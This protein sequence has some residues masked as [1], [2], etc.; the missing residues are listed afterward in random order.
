MAADHRLAV[1]VADRYPSLSI[2]ATVGGQ[3]ERFSDVLDQW[4]TNLA[5]NLL[6]P[7]FAGGRLTA[8]ADRNRAV[9]Q[10]R[11]Y[12]WESALLGACTE[13]EDA[14]VAERGLSE[15]NRILD[16]QLELAGANLERSRA[17]YVNGLTDY[18]TVLTALQA[19]QN[20]QRQAITTQQELVS[21]R[22][23]LYLALGGSW[24]RSLEE[25]VPRAEEQT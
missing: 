4:F 1:A 2:S 19:L 3:A 5:G 16:T 24:S 20:L 8:E 15:T 6:A 10:E 22:I 13:V 14:L 25:P 18:L 9:V 12:A 7:V 11:I 23:R 17:L 21:N